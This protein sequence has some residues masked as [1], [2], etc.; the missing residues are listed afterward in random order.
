M[1]NN[2]L[3]LA[4]VGALSIAVPVSANAAPVRPATPVC[5]TATSS[6]LDERATALDRLATLEKTLTTD[7]YQ[8][9]VAQA[10]GDY[11][12]AADLRADI[13]EYQ[14]KYDLLVAQKR[15]I[16]KDLSA[17]RKC[18]SAVVGRVARHSRARSLEQLRL[19]YLVDLKQQ[20]KA[21]SDAVHQYDMAKEYDDVD[22]A[23]VYRAKLAA[24]K[25]A[26]SKD[27]RQIAAIDS[28]LK[29]LRK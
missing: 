10:Y 20:K 23:A 18:S 24:A 6:L 7:R 27:K 21:A 1:R 19:S 9:S 25:A 26:V 12:A 11:G 28:A 4:L 3:T 29:V 13:A 8:L 2:L 17:L 16:K 14:P 22:R 15:E 5:G